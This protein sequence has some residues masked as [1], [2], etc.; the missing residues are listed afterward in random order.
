[1]VRS[2]NYDNGSAIVE[3]AKDAVAK[4]TEL[5]GHVHEKFDDY[6]KSAIKLCEMVEEGR[7]G[8][9]EEDFLKS[10][11]KKWDSLQAL[12]KKLSSDPALRE[13]IMG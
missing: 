1:M 3:E 12:R 11:K 9:D 6:L 8:E 7:D 13:E 5:E 4:L 10:L 2:D